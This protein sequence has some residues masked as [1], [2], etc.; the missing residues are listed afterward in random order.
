[1]GSKLIIFP[2]SAQKH[3]ISDMARR[4]SRA[5]T[6]ATAVAEPRS[7]RPIPRRTPSPGMEVERFRVWLHDVNTHPGPNPANSILVKDAGYWT[8]VIRETEAATHADFSQGPPHEESHRSYSSSINSQNPNGIIISIADNQKVKERYGTE[9]LP[10]MQGQVFGHSRLRVPPGS[11]KIQ[12]C[13]SGQAPDTDLFTRYL[14]HDPSELPGQHSLWI[15]HIP[16]NPGD[17]IDLLSHEENV[18]H[19]HSSDWP[20]TL[21][22]FYEE[23]EHVPRREESD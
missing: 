6:P 15:Q 17:T 14:P 11:M 8:G 22:R 20:I 2:T 9:E 16:D 18:P 12:C 5:T 19:I 13:C 23:D 10:L 7:R 3:I 1:M 4:T 21:R